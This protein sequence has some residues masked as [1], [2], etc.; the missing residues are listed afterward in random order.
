M[1]EA[2]ENGKESSHSA[3][4]NGIERIRHTKRALRSY[5]VINITGNKLLH[6]SSIPI[7]Y[8]KLTEKSGWK[9]QNSGL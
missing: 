6:I 3:H 1:E 7:Q 5:I 9:N 8:I 2:L 4:A